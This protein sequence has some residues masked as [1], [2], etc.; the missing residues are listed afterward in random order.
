M[1]HFL[2]PIPIVKPCM[3]VLLAFTMRDGGEEKKIT[4]G[5]EVGQALDP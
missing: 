5:Q 4:P 3:T 1:T 2:G